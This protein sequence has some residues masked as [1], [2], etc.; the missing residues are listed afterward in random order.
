[1]W[2]GCAWLEVRV[3]H[4]TIRGEGRGGVS[5]RHRT[6]ETGTAD[7]WCCCLRRGE[8]KRKKTSSPF[9]S[10]D[11][12]FPIITACVSG[13]FRVR[14]SLGYRPYMAQ[15]ACCK[16]NFLDSNYSLERTW[17]QVVAKHKT[18]IG[19]THQYYIYISYGYSWQHK[20]KIINNKT[21]Q[22]GLWD[23]AFRQSTHRKVHY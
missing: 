22:S 6:N 4:K 13:D 19:W 3:K 12:F 15:R 7:K 9:V 23:R 11:A 1:M 8:I 17:L 18:S 14:C 2:K 5:R 10:A 21:H 16:L 20:Q